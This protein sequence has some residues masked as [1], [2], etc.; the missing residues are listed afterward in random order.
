[1]LHTMDQMQKILGSVTYGNSH[2]A[3]HICTGVLR[4][5]ITS[6]VPGATQIHARVSH[7]NASHASDT[8]VI[9][10]EQWKHDILRCA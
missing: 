10:K 5:Y 2:T 6:S 8:S 4:N 7:G 1:M 9:V 3:L